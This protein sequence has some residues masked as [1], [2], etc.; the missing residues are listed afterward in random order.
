MENTREETRDTEREHVRQ[1]IAAGLQEAEGK[2]KRKERE[3]EESKERKQRPFSQCVAESVPGSGS[4]H[5]CCLCRTPVKQSLG[6]TQ[7]I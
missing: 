4:P 2:P 1:S 3:I 6:N 7:R 5:S